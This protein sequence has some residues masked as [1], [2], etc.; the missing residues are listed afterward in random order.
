MLKS[1][2]RR[3]L[4]CI[5]LHLAPVVSFSQEVAAETEK[6]ALE[7]W[8]EQ[9]VQEFDSY[10]FEV[11]GSK[12]QEPDAGTTGDSQLDKSRAG[13]FF[14]RHVSLD[15]R[16]AAGTY[17]QHL[18]PRTIAPTRIRFGQYGPDRSRASWKP[19]APLPAGHPVAGLNQRPKVRGFAGLTAHANAAAGRAIPRVSA[20]QEAKSR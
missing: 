19:R 2:C 12:A 20:Y 10:R 6:S 8:R 15:L 16:R 9:R 14:W 5:L 3:S 11:E 7:A 1:L 4:I 18:R 17:C 13:N